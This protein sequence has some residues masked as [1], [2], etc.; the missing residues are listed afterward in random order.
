MLERC[1]RTC[2]SAAKD[3]RDKI[4]RP[5]AL[6]DASCPRA[7]NRRKT[8]RWNKFEARRCRFSVPNARRNRLRRGSGK[9]A[10]TDEWC[11]DPPRTGRERSA[12]QFSRSILIGVNPE[13]RCYGDRIRQKCDAG[14][15]RVHRCSPRAG[16]KRNPKEL[17]ERD[18][19][20]AG[21]GFDSGCSCE[22]FRHR[23]RAMSAIVAAHEPRLRG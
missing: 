12:S 8:G 21:R 6:R 17:P 5:R 16:V 20:P 4:R 13:G 23:F 22:T 15:A 1:T 9:S 3:P 7:R 10:L 18:W 19:R 11:A 14:G 2:R